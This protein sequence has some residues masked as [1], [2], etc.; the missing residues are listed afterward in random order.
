MNTYLYSQSPQNNPQESTPKGSSPNLFFPLIIIVFISYF[1]LLRPQMRKQKLLDKKRKQLK[2]GDKFVTSGGIVAV[3][4][5]FKDND[6]IVVAEIAKGIK[7]DVV[8]ST[9]LEIFSEKDNS[10]STKSISN[11]KSN[12]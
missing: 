3:A 12:K 9:I 1:L 11:K 4:S 7:V 2:K 6:T 8:K 5:H 10:Q